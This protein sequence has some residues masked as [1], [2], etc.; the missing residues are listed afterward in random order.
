MTATGSVRTVVVMTD[1][2]PMPTVPPGTPP[3]PMPTVTPSPGPPPIRPVF[4]Y[5]EADAALAA[6]D[7]LLDDVARTTTQH[8]DLTGD[9]ILGGSFHGSVR[10]RFED[11]VIEAGQGLDPGS[12]AIVESNRTWL[13]QAVAAAHA[14]DDQYA[15]DLAAWQ[16]RAEGPSV[17]V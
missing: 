1:P 9:L 13:L 8:R 3:V 2:A 10:H 12:T 15:V 7:A 5:A 16:A 4:P 17:P 14:R 11:Q 6:L